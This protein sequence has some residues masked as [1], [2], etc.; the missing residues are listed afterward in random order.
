YI[1]AGTYS[2]FIQDD[3]QARPNLT[4]NLG[5]RWGYLPPTSEKFGNISNLA[6]GPDQSN[7]LIGSRMTLGGSLWRRDRNN[8]GPQVGF[9]WSPNRVAGRD[10]AGRDVGRRWFGLW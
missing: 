6:L 3:W 5:L 8:F 7:P 2:L 10:T 9:A 1:R 4:L